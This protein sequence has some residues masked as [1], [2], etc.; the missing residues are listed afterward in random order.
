MRGAETRGAHPYTLAVNPPSPQI[1]RLK[2]IAEQ[3]PEVRALYLFGSRLTGDARPDSDVDI[4]VLYRAPEPLETTLALEDTFERALGR[5]VDVVD[6]A[7]AGAFLAFDIV[8]G[9]RVFCRDMADAD[10]F[11]LYVLARTGDLLPF[12][13]QRQALLIGG[14]R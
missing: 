11:E 14:R 3:H 4:G 13:R 9:E 6:I 5:R 1:G 7:R 12:E 2:E 8:R 10:R